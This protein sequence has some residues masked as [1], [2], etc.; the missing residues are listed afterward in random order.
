MQIVLLEYINFS[1]MQIVKTFVETDK[2]YLLCWQYALRYQV[3]IMLK[4]YYAG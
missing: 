2:V 3:P 4:N 1:D